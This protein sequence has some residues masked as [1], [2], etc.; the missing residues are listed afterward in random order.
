MHL[1]G[2]KSFTCIVLICLILYTFRIRTKSQQNYVDDHVI[3]A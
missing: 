3:L 1:Q 2:F